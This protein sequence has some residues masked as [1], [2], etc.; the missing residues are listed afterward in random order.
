MD[1]LRY[2]PEFH[3][4]LFVQIRAFETLQ[5]LKPLFPSPVPF[6]ITANLRPL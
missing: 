5:K 6:R 2:E 1:N 3:V 4:S